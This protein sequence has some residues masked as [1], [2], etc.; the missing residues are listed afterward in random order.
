MKKLYRFDPVHENV[1]GFF[2]A[3]ERD[4]KSFVGKTMYLDDDNGHG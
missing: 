3:Y 2:V 1:F 4:V